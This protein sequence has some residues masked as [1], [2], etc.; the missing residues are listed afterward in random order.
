MTDDSRRP[1]SE[2]AYTK[3]PAVHQRADDRRQRVENLNPSGPHEAEAE[4]E[5]AF[6]ELAFRQTLGHLATGV[7]VVTVATSQGVYGMTANAVTSVSLSPPLILVCIDRRARLVNFIQ[8]NGRFGVNLLRETQEPLSR[9]FAR[10]WR[11]EE[12]P[13]HRFQEWAG[14]PHLVGSLGALS[15][16]TSE[17]VEAGDHLIV[18][19]QVAGLRVDDA[20]GS[21]LLY[22]RGQYAGL[23]EHELGP[24]ES[25]ELQSGARFQLYHREWEPEDEARHGPPGPPTH[26]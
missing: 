1:R 2:R 15:C 9:Y 11:S 6:D 20:Y 21:P 25:P 13:E 23:I 7:T 17:I 14:V 16:R 8:E 5:H 26:W 24:P 12:P 4:H 3:M 22:Y 10:S 19:G 18:I